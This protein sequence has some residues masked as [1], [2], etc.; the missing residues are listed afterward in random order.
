[1][2]VFNSIS[3]R[4][5]LSV[6]QQLTKQNINRMK[7]NNESDFEL[8]S[9]DID[10][11]ATWGEK[12]KLHELN[13]LLTKENQDFMSLHSLLLDFY[14]K[15]SKNII[16]EVDDE[17]GKSMIV[18]HTI[19]TLSDANIKGLKN[20]VTEGVSKLDDLDLVVLQDLLQEKLANE[21]YEVCNTIQEIIN[22]KE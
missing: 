9:F 17:D 7:Q 13:T 16:V 20:E 4:E 3:M 11:S 15:Y 22:Q 6:L 5:F 2:G 21:E 18:K 10:E 19:N 8:N 12:N 14:R 1:M